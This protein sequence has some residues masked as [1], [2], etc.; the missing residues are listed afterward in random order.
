MLPKSY[1]LEL[2]KLRSDVKPLAAAAARKVIEKETGK[3][4]EEL[5]K[6]FRDEPL[7]SAS[8]AQA[9]YGVLLDGTRVV[10]KVQRPEIA[11][12]MRDDFVLLKKLAGMVSMTA[13][14]DDEAETIDLMGILKELEKVTEVISWFAACRFSMECLGS[15]SNLNAL[16]LKLNQDMDPALKSQGFVIEHAADDLYTFTAAHVRQSWAILLIFVFAFSLLAWL[17]LTRL[18]SERK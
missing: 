11:E 3:R 4:I 5:Y 17:L 6:E 12:L 14:G 13:E 7:G 10:T 16:E 8:I 9:H 1:C 18:R 2:E 15:I